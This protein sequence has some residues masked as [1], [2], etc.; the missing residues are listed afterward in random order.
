MAGDPGQAW[1]QA[2]EVRLLVPIFALAVAVV[3]ALTDPTSVADLVLM[4]IPV[5]APGL[6]SYLPDVP[7]WLV[8]PAVLG[9]VVLAQRS[10]T[11]EPLMFEAS[12][13][14]FVVA[15][16][17]GSLITAVALGLL[18]VASPVAVSLVETRGNISVGIWILGIAF[19]WLV[20]RAVFRQRQ[21]AAALETTRQALAEQAILDERRRIAR[22]RR[23]ASVSRGG[24]A[25]QHAGAA[26]DR[27]ADAQRRRGGRAATGPVG[28]GDPGAR[29]PCSRRGSRGRA[30]DAR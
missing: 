3:A 28:R 24:G 30:A 13:L 18:A 11:H 6:W 23:G 14:A 19:P 26:A 4:A 16:W 1:A 10:G 2:D 7:L 17:S 25:P 27:G 21:L 29:R 8:A 9:P 22:D 12:V 20:G 5:A 15:R